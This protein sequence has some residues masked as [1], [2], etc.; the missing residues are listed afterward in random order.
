MDPHNGAPTLHILHPTNFRRRGNSKVSSSVPASSAPPSCGL[1][2]GKPSTGGEG[3]FI[4]K[5]ACDTHRET[6]VRG[7]L[8]FTEKV[9]PSQKEM[10]FDSL[11][12]ELPSHDLDVGRLELRRGKCT[13]TAQ[14][15]PCSGGTSLPV[16]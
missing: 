2:P 10:A 1:S 13:Q 14:L 7:T 4:F 3:S 15:L 11:H 9:L 12:H 6:H 16:R 5:N 8:H